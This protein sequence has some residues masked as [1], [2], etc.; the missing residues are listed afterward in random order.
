MPFMRFLPAIL[1]AS[2]LLPTASAATAADTTPSTAA[3]AAAAGKEA[4]PRLLSDLAACKD[5]ASRQ[6]ALLKQLD[7]L[8][9]P[10]RLQEIENTVIDES[11]DPR[12][13]GANII[14]ESGKGDRCVILCAHYD[15]APK[16]E[17]GELSQGIIDNGAAVSVLVDLAKG[18]RDK[19]F[20]N[21]RVAIYFMDFEEIGLLGSKAAASA[22]AGDASIMGVVNL[23]VCGYGDCILLGSTTYTGTHAWQK[24]MRRL[25]TERDV[26]FLTFPM[27]PP[28]DNVSF[29]KTG[30]PNMTIATGS[31]EDA[32]RMWLFLNARTSGDPRSMRQAGMPRLLAEMHSGKDTLS[33]YSPETAGRLLKLLKA[34]LASVATEK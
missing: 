1:L 7:A 8:K 6:K 26:E 23:D 13:K 25:L 10:H 12:E 19:P 28:T 30:V 29:Q 17:S 31:T 2:T 18:L 33:R 24:R 15:A 11:F 5:N 20:E 34:F 27:F 21:L 3:R 9:I 16:D 14:V 32:H 22:T 4:P